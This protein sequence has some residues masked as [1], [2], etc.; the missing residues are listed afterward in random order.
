MTAQI[1]IQ[2]EPRCSICGRPVEAAYKPFCSAHCSNV[3]LARWLGGGY[4]IPGGSADAD[5]DGEMPLERPTAE[6]DEA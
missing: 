6:D 5:E 2:R 1:P 3:D 4:A